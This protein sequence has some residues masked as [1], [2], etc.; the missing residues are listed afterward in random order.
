MRKLF[1][2]LPALVLSLALNATILDIAPNSPQSSDNIRREIRDHISAGDTLRLADGT[3]TESEVITLDKSVT[4]IAADGAHPIIA[5]HYYSKITNGSDVKFIGIKFDGSLYNEGAGANDHC[6]YP[7][8]NT[9]G[10]ELHFE[11]CEFT[12]F[13]SYVL[14]NGGSYSLDSL[15]IN[16]CYFYD[17]TKSSVI[18]FNKHVTEGLQTVKGVHITNS[19]FANNNTTADYSVIY[20]INQTQS[21]V[22]DIELT[23][24]H[25]TFYNNP[26]I[27]SDH[28]SIRSY[29]STKV[30]I[31]NCIFAHPA[32]INFRAT[33]LYGG[34]ITNCLTYNLS[35]DNS[36][37]GH[38]KESS[39]DPV[40]DGNFTA[41]PLFT[42]AANGDFSFAG[43]YETMTISPARGA[44]TDGSDLGDP[45][46]YTAPVLPSTDFATPYAFVGAKAIASN[47]MELDANNYIHSKSSGGSAIWK[48]HANKACYVQITLNLLDSYSAGH[49][50]EVNIFD[51]ENNSIGFATEGSWSNSTGDKLLPQMILL[52]ATG[53]Y[54]IELANNESGS[55]TTIKSITLSYAG[56][57][58]MDISSSANTTLYAADAWYNT[59]ATRA[60]G[61]ISYSSWNSD[62]SWVKWNIATTETKFYDL[63]LHISTT[64]AHQCKVAIYEDESA[65]PVAGPLQE[66]YSEITGDAVD[67][68]LGRINL[69]GGKNYVVKVTNPVSGSLAKIASLTFAP[70]LSTSTTLPGTLAFNNA[71]LSEKAHIT[72]SKLYFNEI[73]DTN[74]QGQW[75]RWNVT[76][77]HDGLF[78]FTLNVESANGQSYKISIF[79][80]S[81]NLVDSYDVKPSS[82]AQTLKH[83]FNL[84]A[85]DY[86]IQVENTTSY[87]KGHLISFVV[88]EPD[89]VITMD[90]NAEDNSA[91][92]N[93]V[94]DENSYDVH[95]LRTL[96]AGMYNTFCLP[97]A[98]NS[99]MCKDIFGNDV[100]IYTLGEAIADGAILNVSLTPATDIYQGTPVFIKP[101]SDVVNPTFSSVQIASA[102]PAAT[103]KTNANFVGSFVKTTLEANS[104][105]LYLGPDNTLYYPNEATPIK[106]FRAWF[107]I[108]D[109]SGP[110]SLIKRMHI[111]NSTHS[112]T[113]I[114][115]VNE[116]AKVGGSEKILENGHLFIIRDGVRYNALG[117]RVK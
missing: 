43:N 117:V 110:A 20:I 32:P 39:T 23:V 69:V 103:T 77:G 30:T 41:D 85:G 112:T 8:D 12:G 14:Y 71:V 58:M 5:Q 2:L 101:A 37:N 106:G 100:E 86:S 50:Y 95:I 61:Q 49:R 84:T 6:F 53:D 48:I 82:G 15:I 87:S 75:A 4:I 29:K 74:P 94:N 83:Y 54:K 109:V 64:N 27:N 36:P 3:Y 34:T 1:L 28:S 40:M 116:S 90:E 81:E 108:H 17:N 47:S 24:D 10:N 51:A 11:D 57:D 105:I 52:P 9:A 7:Y 56:G 113:E 60:D 16:N 107:V 99:T 35:Y 78:L 38:R 13:K 31:S 25:C 114:N 55:T 19:T 96:K 62:D 65:E 66:S 89:D 73:G 91:W 80:D 70:V 44:A 22:A 97:F 104:D 79:D 93:K 18:F 111:V 45:R 98:V 46:W 67:I 68:N 115:L 59:G 102:N 33:C 92:S 76:T 72:D 88:T 21:T 63:T 26:V 42:D